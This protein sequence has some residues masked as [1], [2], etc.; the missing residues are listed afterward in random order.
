MAA[1]LAFSCA[2]WAGQN[3]PE[4]PA[5]KLKKPLIRIDLLQKKGVRPVAVSRDLFSPKMIAG[6]EVLPLVVP[7][8]KTTLPAE[9]GTSGESQPTSLSLHYIGYCYN[10][11]KKKYIALVFFEEQV[12]PVQEGDMLAPGWKILKITAKELEV[13]GPDKKSQTFSLE[14]EQR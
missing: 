4:K 14:G 8:L 11:T 5:V 12:T 1:A 10:E 9:E 6:T 2:G 3:P 7:K 13:E